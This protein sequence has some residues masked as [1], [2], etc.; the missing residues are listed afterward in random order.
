MIKKVQWR[1]KKKKRK[2]KE[3]TIGIKKSERIIERGVE[4]QRKVMFF[5][6][7]EKRFISFFAA[8]FEIR[9]ERCT[10]NVRRFATGVISERT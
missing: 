8:M 3:R 7:I 1:K 9:M 5:Q 2:S 6:E 10:Y 4:F